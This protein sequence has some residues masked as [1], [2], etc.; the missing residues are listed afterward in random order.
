M[1]ANQ[2]NPL[3]VVDATGGVTALRWVEK[4]AKETRPPIGEN[5]DFYAGNIRNITSRYLVGVTL[6]G[7][8]S[9]DIT[10]A[11]GPVDPRWD[12]HDDIRVSS[13]TRQGVTADY[14]ISAYYPFGKFVEIVEQPGDGGEDLI[15]YLFEGRLNYDPESSGSETCQN[16]IPDLSVDADGSRDIVICTA[17]DSGFDPGSGGGWTLPPGPEIEPPPPDQDV[18]EFNSA[19]GSQIYELTIVGSVNGQLVNRS[20][21]SRPN[22]IEG[23]ARRRLLYVEDGLSRRTEYLTNA[24]EEVGG[25]IEPEGNSTIRGYDYRGNV[26]SVTVSAKPDP[27]TGQPSAPPLVTT[28]TYAAECTSA[29]KPKCNKPLTMTDPNLNITEYEY[30]DRGQLT[31]E[32]GPAPAPGAARPVT[33]NTYTERTAM[34]LDANG[35]YVPAGPPISLLT[36][37]SVCRTTENC[38]GTADEIV[39]E[40]DY[41]PTTGPNN[42]LLRGVA[43]TAANG[44]GQMQTLRTCYGYNYF[45]ERISETQPAANLAACP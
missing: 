36:R 33:R 1:P 21:A 2:S 39:T 16:V 12:T 24:F 17:N 41:G 44:D 15:G 32:I 19:F 9:E 37:T 18:P 40:Y 4:T 26:T 45:G 20:H 8:A 6:P 14:A 29:T 27:A 5:Q 3:R 28:Y 43:V 10:I 25:V 7:S 38:E 11:Y 42:L 30:N 34:I 13:I 23:M 35:G 22:R 31:R